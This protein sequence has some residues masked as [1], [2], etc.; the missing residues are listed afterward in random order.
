MIE[1]SRNNESKNLG[2]GLAMVKGM[3]ELHNGFIEF[4]SKENEGTTVHI[5]LKT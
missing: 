4:K 5:K 2:L 1:K 3:V